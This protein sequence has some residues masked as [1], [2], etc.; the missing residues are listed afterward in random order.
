MP[1]ICS[2]LCSTVNPA[3]AAAATGFTVEHSELQITGLCDACAKA[4]R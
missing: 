3:A 1:V 2:S 4:G